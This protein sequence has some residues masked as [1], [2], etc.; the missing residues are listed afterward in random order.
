MNQSFFQI[1]IQTAF[2]MLKLRFVNICLQSCKMQKSV[3]DDYTFLKVSLK[4]CNE[5]WVHNKNQ[6]TS[7]YY[8]Q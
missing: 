2:D 4:Q 6:E 8:K 1:L 3:V 5:N 7:K